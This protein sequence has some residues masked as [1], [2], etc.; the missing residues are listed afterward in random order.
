MTHAQRVRQQVRKG[1]VLQ[2]VEGHI[3]AREVAERV[4]IPVRTVR[5]YLREL[6]REGELKQVGSERGEQGG[7]PRHIYAREGER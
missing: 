2:A 5:E 1:K 7:G 3:T 6:E 4:D